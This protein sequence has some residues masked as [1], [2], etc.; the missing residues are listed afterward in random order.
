MRKL[1]D[2]R[3]PN[4]LAVCKWVAAAVAAFW[5]GLSPTIHILI[6]LMGIDYLT[7]LTGAFV[8]KSID[9]NT[10]FRGLVKKVMTLV[11]IYTCHI[12]TKPL[13]INVDLGNMVA[14]A[15]VVNEV[16]SVVENCNAAGINVPPIILQYL[17]N[18]KNL[19]P[20]VK[21][22]SVTVITS[23][24]TVVIPPAEKGTDKPKS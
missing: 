8:T 13:G 2:P 19:I 7:G 11:L 4:L 15:Y 3:M 12:I 10:S 20:D 16:I 21:G 17:A 14:L 23:T 5:A 9:A 1:L 6:V 18:V 22:S 24:E